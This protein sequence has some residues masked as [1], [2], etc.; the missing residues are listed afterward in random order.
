MQ[1][2]P[3]E[4][5]AIFIENIFDGLVENLTQLDVKLLRMILEPHGVEITVFEKW[6]VAK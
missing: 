2:K 1:S 3:E 5:V 4:T 6:E